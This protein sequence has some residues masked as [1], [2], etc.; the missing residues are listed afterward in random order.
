MNKILL[1]VIT[2]LVA[3]D[4]V[5]CWPLT[6]KELAIID[7]SAQEPSLKEVVSA[8]GR[9]FKECIRVHDLLDGDVAK[10]IEAGLYRCNYFMMQVV[11][12]TSG[13]TY[14]LAK[15]RRKHNHVIAIS[16][17]R[18]LRLHTTPSVGLCFFMGSNKGQPPKIVILPKQTRSKR[19]VEVINYNQGTGSKV[20]NRSRKN[21]V[22][23][24]GGGDYLGAA[25]YIALGL[26]ASKFFW[27]LLKWITS[28]VK[29]LYS[30][31][32]SKFK[33][34]GISIFITVVSGYI[35]KLFS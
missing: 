10:D 11:R 33:E 26:V 14:N 29:V 12:K 8:L 27:P 15:S 35:L 9:E 28:K 21:K 3:G 25:G 4:A 6:K 5:A 7:E 24:S 22:E 16:P 13:S 34:S 20:V 23:D 19:K 2:A 1:V 18:K 32:K 17:V 30:A 31:H